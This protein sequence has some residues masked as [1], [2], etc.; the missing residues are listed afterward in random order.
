MEYRILSPVA[1]PDQVRDFFEQWLFRMGG[2]IISS[3]PL[4]GT[5][6]SFTD[7]VKTGLVENKAQQNMK[8][9]MNFL[10]PDTVWGLFA[11]HGKRQQA[12]DHF[13]PNAYKILKIRY[14][15]TIYDTEQLFTGLEA[16]INRHIAQT[17]NNTRNA[18]VIKAESPL[19]YQVAVPNIRPAWWKELFLPMVRAMYSSIKAR[20]PKSPSSPTTASE[21]PSP[22]VT[23]QKTPVDPLQS[24]ILDFFYAYSERQTFPLTELAELA[25]SEI[26]KIRRAIANLIRTGRLQG[27]LVGEELQ[28]SIDIKVNC[29][30]CDQSYLN[31]V[32]FWQCPQCKRKTCTSCQETQPNRKCQNCGS[33]Q[34][35]MPLLCPK[36][37]TIYQDLTPITNSTCPNCQTPL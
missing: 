21:P 6:Q 29:Q 19:A 7:L 4:K 24:A 31:P 12:V 33:E 37:N 30:L 16:E 1:N 3:Y 18:I 9:L 34:L 10:Q 27:K 8:E 36:C 15:Q 23:P 22:T 35:K 14:D 32:G 25:E 20:K 11:T 26:P 17:N 2:S 28:R 13:H 5:T